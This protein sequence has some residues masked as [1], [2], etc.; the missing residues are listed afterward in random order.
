VLKEGLINAIKH[1]Q[2]KYIFVG[3]KLEQNRV[4]LTV[5]DDG[6]GFCLPERLLDLSMKGHY[7]IIGIHEWVAS[8]GGKLNI[9][10][11]PGK[12]CELSIELP[13]IG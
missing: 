13:L 3:L 10:S 2:S 8:T 7:G 9:S 6:I 1:A 4:E 12:G 11:S 5:K